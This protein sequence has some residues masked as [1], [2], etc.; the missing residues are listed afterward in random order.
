[1]RRFVP[2][3]V[4]VAAVVAGAYVGFVR[5]KPRTRPAGP[6]LV[7]SF[8]P[9]ELGNAIVFETPDGRFIVVD[10]G[11]KR[12]ASELVKYLQLLGAQ[13]LDVIIS[14]PIDDHTGALEELTN[15]FDVKRLIHS[16]NAW[17]SAPECAKGRIAEV[18][19]SAGDS[20]RLS[21]KVRLE[22][23]SPPR[24]PE[25]QSI[26]P[27]ITRVSFGRTR[28]LLMSDALVEDEAYMIRSGID[29]TSNVLV[30]PRHGR[31]GGTSL[32]LI[33]FVRP[34]YCIVLVGNGNDKP[35]R[36]V[37]NRI[38][39]EN[40]G[41]EVYRTDLNGRINLISDGRTVRKE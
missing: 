33:S 4:L 25:S 3:I 29:L 30:V 17:E 28:F 23:L 24:E 38:R 21:Q 6:I 10:P 27:L 7:A 34:E 16:G 9:A 41:A 14:N 12:T 20:I 1:M 39:T 37:L 5:A 11:P 40:T 2:I 22:A 19:L 26:R 8:L 18:L 13:S 35:S 31:Y 36:I 32:E 15:S